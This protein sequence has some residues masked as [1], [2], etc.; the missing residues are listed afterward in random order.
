MYNLLVI[1]DYAN[2]ISFICILVIKDYADIHCI[3]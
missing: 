3:I 1:K 2:I